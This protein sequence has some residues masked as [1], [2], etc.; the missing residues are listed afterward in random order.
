MLC[1]AG[2]EIVAGFGGGQTS[3]LTGNR[4]KSTATEVCATFREVN[5]IPPHY[6]VR[7]GSTLL[8]PRSDQRLTDVSEH[9]AENA[10]MALAP[11]GPSLR[12]A[13]NANLDARLTVDP[14]KSHWWP[15][16]SSSPAHIS[17]LRM[18][19]ASATLGKTT[20]KSYATNRPNWRI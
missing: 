10:T 6:L 9:L 1:I 13:A 7:A 12:L 4:Y 5:G 18:R 16:Q 2:G 20:P 8:V 11:D 15:C 17:R 14:T 3:S 19:P